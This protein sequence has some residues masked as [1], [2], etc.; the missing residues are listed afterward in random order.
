M[1]SRLTTKFINK[2][3]LPHRSIIFNT[4]QDFESFMEKEKINDKNINSQNTKC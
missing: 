4:D 2:Y 3:L 1:K